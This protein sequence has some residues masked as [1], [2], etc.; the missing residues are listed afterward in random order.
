MIGTGRIGIH[1]ALFDPVAQPGAD[2]AVI[3]SR[4]LALNIR[5]MSGC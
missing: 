4:G 5:S 2:K 3:Q 1:P